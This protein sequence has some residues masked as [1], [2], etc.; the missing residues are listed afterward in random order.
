MKTFSFFSKNDNG[1]IELLH[2]DKTVRRVVPRIKGRYY[3]SQ[4]YVKEDRVVL[5]VPMKNNI[6]DIGS[7]FALYN[8]RHQIMGL[9][10]DLLLLKRMIPDF[11]ESNYYLKRPTSIFAEK[12][13][14]DIP[15]PIDDIILFTIKPLLFGLQFLLEDGLMYQRIVVSEFDIKLH[16]KPGY[17]IKLYNMDP[18]SLD[19]FYPLSI[20]PFSDKNTI[21]SEE[22]FVR[23]YK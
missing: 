2:S 8:D 9:S 4:Y 1:E 17:D 12:K 15:I 3:F 7:L 19:T 13:G 5:E 22:V 21:Y 14:K 11:E 18:L 6:S 23:E 10:F 16:F 20:L